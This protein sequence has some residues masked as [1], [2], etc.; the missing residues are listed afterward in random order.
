[1]GNIIGASGKGNQCWAEDYSQPLPKH[2]RSRIPE[3]PKNHPGK[4][5]NLPNTPHRV[6]WTDG[7]GN[8]VPVAADA[9]IYGDPHFVGAESGEYDIQGKP[10]TTYNILSDKGIQVNAT[11]HQWDDA[12]S[13]V[14]GAMGI[15]LANKD[16][17][18]D[19]IKI[20]K[21]GALTING[22]AY[23]DDGA[24]LDG[25][26]VKEGDNIT[27]TDEAYTLNVL[28]GAHLDIGFSA[29]NV[30]TDGIMPHG[31]WG[32]TADGDG[33]RRDGDKGPGA[34][35]GGAIELANGDISEPG[36]TTAVTLYAVDGL[37]DTSF[38]HFN[39][40]ADN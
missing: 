8:V 12:G 32:Q 10:D 37:F 29:D 5:P 38:E 14:M 17:G 21:N 30:A 39:K 35:G 19:Q 1:M 33:V 31:L 6:N 7:S 2:K 16:G 25:K 18:V 9:Q 4:S 3:S 22:K 24:Y 20:G 28:A 26:V 27:I 36:D 15:T 11:F 23:K 40:F 34:Q 13:T